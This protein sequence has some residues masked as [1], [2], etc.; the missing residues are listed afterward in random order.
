MWSDGERKFVE[1]L[2]KRYR[3]KKKV[4]GVKAWVQAGGPCCLLGSPFCLSFGGVWSMPVNLHMVW[5]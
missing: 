4:S 5:K 2:G 3:R 1:G